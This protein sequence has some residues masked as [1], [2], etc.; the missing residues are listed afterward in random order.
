VH[1]WGGRKSRWLTSTCNLRDLHTYTNTPLHNTYTPIIPTH[2]HHTY[3]HTCHLHL[4]ITSTH[5]SHLHTHMSLA[6]T[7]HTYT[8]ITLTHT[9]MT[10]T[11]TCNAEKR[12]RRKFRMCN[13]GVT[14]NPVSH[15]LLRV[16]PSLPP[17]LLARD[18]IPLAMGET[19]KLVSLFLH[20]SADFQA[21]RLAGFGALVMV[22]DL[23]SCQS[24][25]P[26]LMA[27][28]SFQ[29]CR[30]HLPCLCTSFTIVMGFP[31]LLASLRMAHSISRVL[32]SQLWW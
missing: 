9:H 4:H 32:V 1:V 2:T 23:Q 5:T 25:C 29:S 30:D 17:N 28:V 24:H 18:R 3:I 12:R 6:P 31:N 8:H 16:V 27:R 19:S 13:L 15:P 11:P 22:V 20:C 7:H 26:S 21:C 14:S 10:L